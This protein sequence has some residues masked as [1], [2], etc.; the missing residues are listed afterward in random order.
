MTD[1][2]VMQKVMELLLSWMRVVTGWV[3]DF[4][5]ADRGTGL[6]AWF[7]DHWVKIALILILAGVVVDWLI[8]MIRWR[9][10]WL[11][12][13]KRQIIYE[14]VPRKRQVPRAK[15]ARGKAGAQA[16]PEAYYDPFAQGRKE[17]PY[18]SAASSSSWR[19]SRSWPPSGWSTIQM[20][21][22]SATRL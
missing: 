7:S 15:A 3:W 4:F 11:W 19:S 17:D 13:R 12:L 18:A 16:G 1:N 2:G 22:V 20:P 21:S 14:E 9:P 6:I 8:W 10:Y 5:Q